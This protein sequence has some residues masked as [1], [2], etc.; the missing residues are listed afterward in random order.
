MNP[1]RVH[2]ISSSTLH[3]STAMCR[4][5]TTRT[6]ITIE[7]GEP[8]DFFVRTSSLL[9]A[10]SCHGGVGWTLG[11]LASLSHTVRRRPIHLHPFSSCCRHVIFGPWIWVG[12]EWNCWIDA[13]VRDRFIS[14]CEQIS[15]MFLFHARTLVQSGTR[16][17]D[18]ARLWRWLW[19][20][21]V[22]RGT[23]NTLSLALPFLRC[24][25]RGRR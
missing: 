8:V 11:L 5:I 9:P 16:L 17:Y 18:T 12:R 3:V 20:L 7:P 14:H 1:I 25:P 15:P 19:L 10:P 24:K 21:K 22:G 23:E 13:P 6:L 4:T 2:F